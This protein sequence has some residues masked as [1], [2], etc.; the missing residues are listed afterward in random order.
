MPGFPPSA[1]ATP[2][3]AAVVSAALALQ[4]A[5]CGPGAPVRIG[6]V[7]PADFAA[8]AVIAAGEMDAGGIAPTRILP[9][10]IELAEFDRFLLQHMGF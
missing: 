3:V 4:A 9:K 2:V 5:G 8:A 6:V 10:P 1:A 7:L